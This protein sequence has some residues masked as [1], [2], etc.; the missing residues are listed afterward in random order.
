MI[1]PEKFHFFKVSLSSG[2]IS[3]EVTIE[4]LL[5]EGEASYRKYEATS[6]FIFKYA[7]RFQ[8]ILVSVILEE[9]VRNIHNHAAITDNYLQKQSFA[10]VLQNRCS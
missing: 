9:S 7:V 1:L 5:G 3:K 4:N 2:L 6:Y 8:I 10:D